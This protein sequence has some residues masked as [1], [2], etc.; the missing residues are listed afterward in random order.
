MFDII[1]SANPMIQYTCCVKS[2]ENPSWTELAKASVNLEELR[3]A[4]QKLP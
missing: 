4:A 1:Y 3:S 2:L